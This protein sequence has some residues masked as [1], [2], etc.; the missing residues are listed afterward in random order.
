MSSSQGMGGDRPSRD[1]PRDS[2]GPTG[3]GSGGGG[4]DKPSSKNPRDS[5]PGPAPTG[6]G[7]KGPRN[8]TTA[9]QAQAK[10]HGVT[11][12][13]YIDAASAYRDRIRD[14]NDEGNSFIDNLGNM[15]GGLLGLDEMEPD[16]DLN[17][18]NPNA[19]WGLDP[20]AALTSFAGFA[21]GMP[22][23]TGWAITKAGLSAAGIE[24]PTINLGPDVFGGIGSGT[25]APGTG[26]QKPGNGGNTGKGAAG[27][28]LLAQ[29]GQPKATP[30][31]PQTQP[32]G[33]TPTPTNQGA[34]GSSKLPTP[35]QKFQAP[36]YYAGDWA[37]DEATKKVVWKLKQN[38]LLAV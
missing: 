10:K 16:F 5:K 6:G 18:L 22:I 25:S 4:G 28:G 8:D 35:Q 26:Q 17:N 33:Q 23:G 11:P 7:K 19:D 24:T 29:P 15:L 12:D 14:E 31:T 36:S 3:G 27:N 30:Q 38:G 9:T 34:G 32:T 1:N 20:I 13:H 21:T 2:K 37:W